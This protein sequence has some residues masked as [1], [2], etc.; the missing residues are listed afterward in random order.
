M[1]CEDFNEDPMPTFKLG[2]CT[3][4]LLNF[5]WE[6][7][8]EDFNP[9]FEIISYT[10]GAPMTYIK[11]EVFSYWEKNIL[12]YFDELMDTLARSYEPYTFKT[13][14]GFLYSDV[15]EPDNF[16]LFEKVVQALASERYDNMR[17]TYICPQTS[18]FY[19]QWKIVQQLLQNAKNPQF[20]L[21]GGMEALD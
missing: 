4:G 11:P 21:S 19:K 18:E 8:R 5:D 9:S 2:E 7:P 1:Y 3:Y 14:Y 10:T 20:I 16:D 17:Y 6:N 12:G 13:F 15:Y